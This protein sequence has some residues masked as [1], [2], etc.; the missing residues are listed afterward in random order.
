MASVWRKMAHELVGVGAVPDPVDDLVEIAADHAARDV[1]EHRQRHRVDLADAEVGVDQVDADRRLPQE[2]LELVAPVAQRLL[3][4]APQPRQLELRRH[5]GEQLAGAERL[6]QVLVGAGAEPLDARLL[7][8]PR[9]EQDDRDRRGVAASARIA[10]I[11]PKPSRPGIITSAS[12]RS[13]GRARM[14]ASAAWPSA[15]ASTS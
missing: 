9:R 14:L 13:G 11:R 10:A 1:A 12:T 7:A 15:T 6:D 2:R 5:A 3:G 4:V 8:G